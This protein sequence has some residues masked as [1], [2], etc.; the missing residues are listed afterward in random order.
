[1]SQQVEISKSRVSW[2]DNA[3][4]II[5]LCVISGHVSGT[6]EGTYR[7]PTLNTFTLTLMPAF[8]MLSGYCNLHSMEKIDSINE[9]K[10]RLVSFFLS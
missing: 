3:K 10:K 7:L 2:I 4:A 8:V 9:L 5:M 6:L 1:M